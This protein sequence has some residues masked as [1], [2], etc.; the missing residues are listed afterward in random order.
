MNI[1]GELEKGA[2]STLLLNEVKVW[3]ASLV[4]SRSLDNRQAEFA[5]CE[6]F[7]NRCGLA[8]CFSKVYLESADKVH[9]DYLAELLCVLVFHGL[10]Y[11]RVD[12]GYYLVPVNRKKQ[13]DGAAFAAGIGTLMQQI[14]GDHLKVGFLRHLDLGRSENVSLTKVA[15]FKRLLER[16][17]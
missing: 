3:N 6:A 10:E 14:P 8:S 11:L 13:V 16:Y 2:D 17:S 12:Q 15:T 1:L 9:V 7:L 4:Q 5:Q